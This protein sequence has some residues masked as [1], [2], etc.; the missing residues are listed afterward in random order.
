MNV[1]AL[2][3]KLSLPSINFI[4]NATHNLTDS[5]LFIIAGL[6]PGGLEI[7]QILQTKYAKSPSSRITAA[8][9]V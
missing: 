3:Q 5:N 1:L 9:T 6:L 4:Y 2:Q 8:N 7:S